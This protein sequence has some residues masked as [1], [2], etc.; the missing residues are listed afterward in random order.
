MDNCDGSAMVLHKEGQTMAQKGNGIPEGK[1]RYTVTLTEK[2]MTDMQAY[3]R[4]KKAPLN[5]VSIMLDE[6]LA[7][8]LRTVQELEAVQ[9]RTGQPVGLGDVLTVVGKI[10]TDADSKQGKLL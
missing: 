1:K 7:S 10:M 6:Q 4:L 8:I 5:L 3:L 9:E 2:T